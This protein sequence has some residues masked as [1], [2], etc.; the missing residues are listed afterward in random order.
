MKIA[1]IH[2]RVGELDGVSLEMDKWRYVL[3]NNYDHEVIY[4]AGS[5]GTT[6]GYVIPELALDYEPSIL[7]RQNAFTE[8]GDSKTGKDLEKDISIQV[9]LIKSRLNEFFNQHN[10]NFI[11]PNNVFCLPINIPASIA[12]YEVI[13]DLSLTGIIH[14]HDFIWERT[15]YSPTCPIIQDYLDKYFPPNLP[16]FKH[17]VINSIA[18]DELKK[19]KGLDSTVV[20]NVFYFEQ[21]DWVKDSFNS[22]IRAALNIDE[23]DLVVLQATRIVDRKG[24]ELIIDLIS[25]M[26]KPQNLEKLIDKPLYDGRIFKSHNKII[27]VMPNL[28]EQIDYQK[29]LEEKCRQL[30][31]SYLFCNEF[32]EHS[33]IGNE[34]SSD[35]KYNLWDSYVH[36]DIISYP[37]LIEG[38]GNQFLEAVKA[39]L[40]IINFDYPVYKEDIGPLGFETISLGSKYMKVDPQGLVSV[41][42][43]ILSKAVDEVILLL[44]NQQHRE[45]IVNKNYLIGQDK[46]SIPALKQY[47]Q[48]LL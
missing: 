13:Q 43:E 7:I 45:K 16:N 47:L 38:W 9:K 35:K 24:I 10:I 32:F 21:D 31:V 14:S 1:M 34:N 40:P 20:P 22:D 25:E 3:E 17:V 15:S 42:S 36:S 28:I 4:L 41:S 37:S 26:N 30:N 18:K 23:N 39:R 44:Q 2:F 8:L 19:R 12:L 29:K 48:P 5:L 33:R 27:L 11:I 6:D 46:L